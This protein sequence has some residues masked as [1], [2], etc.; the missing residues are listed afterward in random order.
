MVRTEQ[1]HAENHE[2]VT[3]GLTVSAIA[4]RVRLDRKTVRRFMGAE[5]AADL[6]RPH[7]RRTTA[8]DPY[9]THLASRW[10]EEQHV[11]VFVFNRSGSRA[12]A[13]ASVPSD[14]SWQA[15]GRQSRDHRLM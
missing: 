9:L 4:R 6:P 10:R 1:R 15:G 7:G 8:L 3:Q 14:V 13:P 5:L 11:T 12:I 2:L